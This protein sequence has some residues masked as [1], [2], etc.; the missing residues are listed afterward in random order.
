MYLLDGGRSATSSHIQA[1]MTKQR[2]L[3][4]EGGKKYRDRAIRVQS[5]LQ[6]LTDIF[7]N[8]IYEKKSLNIGFYQV[9]SEQIIAGWFIPDNY[10]EEYVFVEFSMGKAMKYRPLPWHRICK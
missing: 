8:D 10:V 3:P 2:N 6:K 1:E 9:K 4:L 7:R 5:R